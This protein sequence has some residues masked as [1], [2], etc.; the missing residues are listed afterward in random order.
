MATLEIMPVCA[1][2]STQSQ[3]LDFLNG[4][5][6]AHVVENFR[7]ELTTP[8]AGQQFESGKALYE[9]ANNRGGLQKRTEVINS[10][11]AKLSE[12]VTSRST[13]TADLF[14]VEDEL[15]KKMNLVHETQQDIDYL[16]A[17]YAREH[18]WIVKKEAHLADRSKIQEFARDALGRFLANEYLSDGGGS[19]SAADVD[20]KISL[21]ENARE[22]IPEV[23]FLISSLRS[24]RGN[25]SVI[26]TQV[27]DKATVLDNLIT[28][29]VLCRQ[30]ITRLKAAIADIDVQVD[31]ILST[32]EPQNTET[33]NH[34]DSRQ[35]ALI[36]NLTKSIAPTSQA[37]KIISSATRSIG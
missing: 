36:D 24:F 5:P 6:D 7:H 22:L 14:K 2:V 11:I 26:A 15:F 35:V 28:G 8:V 9:G 12:L 17:T 1:E 34:V 33:E 27:R 19:A 32:D 25:V 23:D 21:T 13:H 31:S 4:L 37:G 30:E 18:P 3:G 10:Q 16:C 29:S 20:T